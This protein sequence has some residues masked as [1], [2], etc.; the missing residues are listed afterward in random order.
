MSLISYNCTPADERALDRR[1]FYGSVMAT[2]IVVLVVMIVGAVVAARLLRSRRNKKKRKTED[3]KLVIKSKVR[4]LIFVFLC[5][6]TV[7]TRMFVF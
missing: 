6:S 1:M 5:T 4:T 2:C 7:R 3:D